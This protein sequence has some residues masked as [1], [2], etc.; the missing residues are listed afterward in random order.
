V[1]LSRR[2]CSGHGGSRVTAWLVEQGWGNSWGIFVDTAAEMRALRQH[3]RQF[4]MVYSPEAKPLYFRYYDPRVFRTFLPTCTVDELATWFG[5]VNSYLVEDEQPNVLLH[6]S[7]A[8]GDLQ[9]QK[10]ALN[11]TPAPPI[12]EAP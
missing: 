5:P 1:P 7:R 4:V 6:Y 8:S 3:L 9:L 2:A 10:I 11:G 12:R